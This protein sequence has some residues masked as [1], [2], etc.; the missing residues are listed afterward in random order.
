MCGWF[1]KTL[2]YTTTIGG[3]DGSRTHVR[4]ASGSKRYVR[5][6]W[7]IVCGSPGARFHT[8]QFSNTLTI[9]N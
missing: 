6:P 1:N 9:Q 5:I 4:P 8:R 7:L 3:G 2:G